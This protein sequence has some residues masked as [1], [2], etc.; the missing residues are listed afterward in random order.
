ME[1]G[2]VD[3]APFGKMVPQAVQDRVLAKKAE[4]ISGKA[5]VFVGPIADQTGEVK[6]AAG[7]AAPDK[8][9]LGMSWFVQGVI[10]ST[11]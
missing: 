5:K 8:A 4:I 3:L 9:L 10:G 11:E 6:I 1:I 2:I 7:V